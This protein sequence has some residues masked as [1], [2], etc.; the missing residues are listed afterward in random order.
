MDSP[1]FVEYVK[2]N[3]LCKKILEQHTD[4]K[5][6]EELKI[7]IQGAEKSFIKAVEKHVVAC[8]YPYMKAVSTDKGSFNSRDKQLL[9]EALEELLKKLIIEN[10]TVFFNF[11][12]FLLFELY[13]Y[14]KHK[15]YPVTEEYKLEI[16][17]CMICLIESVSEQIID[18]L[19]VKENIPKFSQIIYVCGELAKKEKSRDLRCTAIKC[20]TTLAKVSDT[21]DLY[22]TV[23]RDRVSQIFMFFLPGICST[24]TEIGLENSVQ[25]GHRVLREMIIAYGRIISVVMQDYNPLDRTATLNELLAINNK[26]SNRAHSKFKDK[27]EI[28][29]YLN[30]TQR[31]LKWYKMTDD[32]LNISLKKLAH[33]TSYDHLKVKHALIDMVL[34]ISS[35]CFSTMPE[36]V[37]TLMEYLIILSQDSDPSVSEKSN[38]IILENSSKLSSGDLKLVFENLEEGFFNAINS[39]PRKF[40]SIDDAEKS[41]A[42]NLL[43]GYVKLFGSH[44]LSH[45]LLSPATLQKLTEGLLYISQLDKVKMK[46]LEEYGFKDLNAE[47]DLSTPWLSFRYFSDEGVKSKIETF[48]RHLARSDAFEIIF[49]SLYD[50]FMYDHNRDKE[51]V[52]LINCLILGFED[53]SPKQIELLNSI[54]N[55]Y[56][57]STSNDL[58]EFLNPEEFSVDEVRKNVMLICLLTEGIGKISLAMKKEF[59]IYL[60]NSL[61]YVLEKAGN[62]NYLISA[63]GLMVLNNIAYACEYKNIPDLIQD[64]FRYFSFQV[65]MR[66]KRQNDKTDVLNVLSVVFRYCDKDVLVYMSRIVEEVLLQ[67]SNKFK[68]QYAPDYLRVFKMFM[69]TLR[70]WFE[71]DDVTEPIKSKKQKELEYEDFKV[72]G[73]NYKEDDFSDDIM[74]GK[75]AE[76]MYWEDV[77]RKKQEEEED[78]ENSDTGYK[79]PEPPIHIK[80]T[81]S[82]LKRS[83]HFL[84]SKNQESR[85]LVLEILNNGVEILKDWEDE[86][87]PIVHQI[88]SPLVPRFND[89]EP[90]IVRLSV[91]LLATLAVLSKD[92]IRMRT[93]K[94]LLPKIKETLKKLAPES[95][96]KDKG[97]AYRYT[98]NYKLQIELLHNIGP[99]LAHLDVDNKI[100]EEIMNIVLLYLSKKQPRDLQAEALGFF[101]SMVDYDMGIVKE[102]LLSWKDKITEENEVNVEKIWVILGVK[103]KESEIK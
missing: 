72:S 46:L 38:K 59:K 33:L 51:A 34:E 41:L 6:L 23:L 53:P 76:E 1:S 17:K 54:L 89:K 31:N 71:V 18:Q 81:T 60:I 13:D 90:L 77:E 61:Y 57:E 3:N 49:D 82:I 44:N 35:K 62:G 97:S 25:I 74:E 16:L 28:D 22:D 92:F 96:L 2:L 15:V 85:I 48:C 11:Y 52:F 37:S 95:F 36:S 10:V 14:T 84:P 20:I 29:Q 8:F 103:E 55:L 87:L 101:Q 65:K 98:Q 93:T 63:A 4:V 30:V 91:K 56:M 102:K 42:M 27:K 9:V 66:L 83:L 43:I 67:T 68:E 88:W 79:K 58:R 21:D 75:T 70:R 69:L 39:L 99:I 47:P 19:Y 7:T 32:K 78:E 5:L 100:I 64:N 86:L 94:E 40:N 73:I 24:F 80:L 50:T 26:D 45:V 12:S